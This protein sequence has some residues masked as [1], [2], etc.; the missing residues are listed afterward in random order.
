MNQVGLRGS[1]LD[2]IVP[3]AFSFSGG[4]AGNAKRVSI[5]GPFNHWKPNVHPLRKVPEGDWVTTVYLPPGRVVYYFDVDGAYWLDPN[6]DGRVPNARGSEYSVRYIK[7]L[8]DVSPP[9][10]PQM[11]VSMESNWTFYGII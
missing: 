3:V 8:S 7:L 5:I 9:A 2:R 1:L 4:L 11:A 10:S 6:D